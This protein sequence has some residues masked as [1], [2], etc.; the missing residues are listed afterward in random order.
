LLHF[1]NDVAFLFDDLKLFKNKKATRKFDFLPWLQQ[2]LKTV[3]Q[4]PKEHPVWLRYSTHEP[5]HPLLFSVKPIYNDQGVVQSV[6]LMIYDH[7]AH[8]EVHEKQRILD[9]ALNSFDGQFV[10]NDKGYIVQP[11]YAFC[12]YTG[13]MPE[14]LKSMTIL[15]WIQQQVSLKVPEEEILRTLLEESRWSGELQ[16]NPDAST[17]FHAVL[18]LSMITD[19]HKNIECYVG[20]L[21]D[22]THIKETLN[23]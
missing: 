7:S 16:L 3:S 4:D 12:A 21:Q 9:V 20:T 8:A 23:N 19:H 5:L 15:N 1:S 13:L 22:I 18:S 6:L 11:N 14:Q 2:C 17:T 10:T